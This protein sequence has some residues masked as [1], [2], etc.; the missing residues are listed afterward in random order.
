MG[1]T[2][3]FLARA[4]YRRRR[5]IDALRVMP[6]T[7]ALLFLVPMLGAGVMTRSTAWSG[8]YLFGV[9]F[10]LILGAYLIV[11]NLARAPGGVTSDPLEAG[12]GED[13]D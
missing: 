12:P 7:G 13:E 9:W 6:V 1:R 11:R 10:L 5:L 2:P 4:T 8:V 3:T